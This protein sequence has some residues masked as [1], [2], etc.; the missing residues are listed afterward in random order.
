MKISATNRSWHLR[1]SLAV[2]AVAALALTGCTTTSADS[3]ETSSSAATGAG[4]DQELYDLL[5]DEI[6]DSKVINVALYHGDPPFNFEE[7]GEAKGIVPE[8]IA[9]AEERWGVE[10]VETELP[11][12]GMMPALQADQIDVM[13]LSL[14]DTLE[15]EEVVDQV[16]YIRAGMG[17]IVQPGNPEGIESMDDLCGKIAGTAKGAIQEAVLSEQAE[18]CEAAG[19]PM[20]E[21]L[22]ADTNAGLV[23]MQSETL[24][25]WLGTYAPMNWIANNGETDELYDLAPLSLPAGFNAVTTRRTLPELGEAFLALMKSL[26]TEGVYQEILTKYGAEADILPAD[27]IQLNGLTA[28]T[29]K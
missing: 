22:L 12:P 14:F 6:K 28:G 26:E 1:S 11:F 9:A 21:R 4:F 27:L 29:L 7:N 16:S 13:W 15:R 20:D 24:D 3:D 10:F 18:K 23:A 17:L 2:T 8:L 25:A 19:N 5:P